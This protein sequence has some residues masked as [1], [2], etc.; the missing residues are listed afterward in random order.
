M[1]QSAFKKLES[2][3][4][5]HEFVYDRQ[6]LLLKLKK[7]FASYSVFDLMKIQGYLENECRYL[8]PK[9]RNK[10]KKKISEHL[11]SNFL[12]I[13]SNMESE[14]QE[15]NMK[16]YKEFLTNF[17][18]RLDKMTDEDLPQ[19]MVLYHLLA[20]YNIFITCTPPHPEGTPFP[21]G[22]FIEK[23][24]DEYYCPVKDKQGDNDEAIC[25]YC[26]AIQSEI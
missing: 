2:I 11:F 20:I 18:N 9:Y 24:G 16:Q 22:F 21:G 10:Y 3:Q 6:S 17:Q 23:I 12:A 19:M 26:V 4:E 7:E 15:L 14:N 13:I 8:P 5:L 1:V 25:R